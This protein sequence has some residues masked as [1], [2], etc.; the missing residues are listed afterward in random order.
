MTRRARSQQMDALRALAIGVLIVLFAAALSTRLVRLG[1]K[2]FMHD[3]SLFA[4]YSYCIHAWQ[5]Y[6]Y[7]PMLHGPLLLHLTAAGFALFGDSDFTARLWP[8]LLGALCVLAPW[9]F[10]RR[11]G[12]P[13][14]L[15]AA[16]MFCFSPTLMY[17]SRFMRNDIPLLFFGLLFLI[18]FDQWIRRKRAPWAA[19]ALVFSAGMMVCVKENSIFLFFTGATYLALVLAVDLLAGAWQA[20]KERTAKYGSPQIVRSRG[21]Y[22]THVLLRLGTAN[23]LAWV[24]LVICLRQ[25]V[26]GL[27]PPSRPMALA[28]G[29]MVVLT[30]MLLVFLD[31]ARQRH[32]GRDAHASVFAR[33]VLSTWMALGAGLLAALAVYAALF[34]SMYHF[35]GGFFQIYGGTIA[36]WW[37]QH[38]QHRLEGP[39]HYYAFRLLI[40]EIGP[41]AI[42]LA[43]ALTVLARRWRLLVIFVLGELAIFIG[44]GVWRAD[45]PF[46]PLW[47]Y[48]RLKMDQAWHLYFALTAGWLA[49]CLAVRAI[50]A[51]QAFHGWLVWWAGLSFLEYS[52]AGEKVPWV[53]VHIVA[54]IIL[55]AGSEVGRL[56]KWAQAAGRGGM[57]RPL[58]MTAALAAAIA[59]ISWDAATAFEV[60]FKRSSDPGEM[61]IYNHTMTETSDMVRE[62][63]EF[64]EESGAGHKL[65]MTVT[66]EAGWPL[67]WYFRR[68]EKMNAPDPL[69]TTSD[70]IVI[71]DV[72]QISKMPRVFEDYDFRKVGLRRAWVPVPL[73]AAAMALAAAD[74]LPFIA[75]DENRDSIER[76]RAD[77][78]KAWDYFT[79]RKPWLRPGEDSVG[80]PYSV[81]YLR[82]RDTLPGYDPQIAPIRLP[83]TA[84]ASPTSPA[85]RQGR[86]AHSTPDE[87]HLKEPAVKETLDQDFDPPASL[88]Q[89]GAGKKYP[90]R[91]PLEEN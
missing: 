33:H 12:R 64:A 55:L 29:A 45:H 52:Y 73:D 68:Y 48:Q 88:R 77:W 76:G 63:E 17:Y 69:E 19:F 37:G 22:L 67:F 32:L 57:L 87:E 83:E 15:C 86:A 59:L 66:G 60:C 53:G 25:L 54:P 84:P 43:G 70:P 16:A 78:R 21:N 62:I 74:A 58:T 13:G 7:N 51:G 4:Y 38:Q 82:R 14:A 6:Q 26:P 10:R 3:E 91:P 8:A 23:C 35:R 79:E 39:F 24:F 31:I 50:L 65:E 9:A 85:T 90:T 20:R 5:N 89:S 27:F 75:A 49:L 47:A 30:F 46:D 81:T 18:G 71:A 36:Y 11:I 56:A 44:L 40:Y 34:T 41:V 28:L 72:G 42:V 80:V 2:P 1:E 61:L